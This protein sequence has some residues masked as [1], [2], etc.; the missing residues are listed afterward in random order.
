MRQEIN[1]YIGDM[2]VEFSQP[3]QILYSYTQ[4]ELTNPTII[5]NSFSK[6]IT[7]E[8]TNQNNNIFGQFW[9]LERLQDYGSYTETYFNASRKTP[10]TLYVN[11]D[12]YESGYVKLVEVRKTHNGIEYDIELFGGLGQFFYGLTYNG[13]TGNKLKLSDLDYRN[14]SDSD[15]E[16]NFT[17]DKNTLYQAWYTDSPNADSGSKWHYI[18]FAPCYNGL[19]S[20]DFAPDKVL[21]NVSGAPNEIIT[22][23]D[24]DKKII[25]DLTTTGTYITY[26]DG[27]VN[28]TLP[29]K[30][31]EWEMGDI[32]AGQ[33]RPVI[34]LKEIVN[35]CERYMAK[36]ENGSWTVEK[37][38]E[39]F[40]A[41]N[42]YWEKTWVTLPMLS[43]INY[44]NESDADISPTISVSRTS[45]QDGYSVFAVSGMTERVNKVTFAGHYGINSYSTISSYNKLYTS[46][47]VRGLMYV[48]HHTE[49]S[50]VKDYDGAVILR[51]EALNELGTVVATSPWNYLT[52]KRGDEYNWDLLN[53]FVWDY[54]T[55]SSIIQ[56]AGYFKKSGSTY[57]WVDESG[58]TQDLVFELDLQ[59]RSYSSIR[60]VVQ[61]LGNQNLKWNNTGILYG[62]SDI[63]RTYY[64]SK[65][66]VKVSDA[67][68]YNEHLDLAFISATDAGDGLLSGKVFGK[69]DILNTS[70]SPADYLIS[71]C[72]LFNLHFRKDTDK[73]IIHID[74]RKNFYQSGITIDLND[75]IDRSKKIKITPTA[76]EKQWYDFKLPLV[77]GEFAEDYKATTDFD[78]G[79]K[80]IN[81]GYDFDGDSKDLLNGNVYKSAV[82]ALEK[83]KYY[84]YCGTGVDDDTDA[85]FQPWMLEGLKYNLYNRTDSYD[86]CEIVLPI[87]YAALQGISD[88]AKYYDLYDKP[89][90]HSEDNKAIDGSNV[91]L[92]FNGFEKCLSPNSIEVNYWLTDDLPAMEALN[93][94]SCWLYTNCEKNSEGETIARKVDR[95]PKF[96]RYR[97]S[98]N[99]ISHSL[100]FGE[101][102]QLYAPNLT[103][104]E[105]ST[106]YYNYWKSY[107]EDIY[108]V[109]TKVLDCYVRLDDKPNP[110][111]LRRFYWFDNSIWRINKIEDWSISSFDTTK[112]QFIKVQDI[113]NYS[114]NTISDVGVI[115]LSA[116][117]TTVPTTGGSVTFYV[118]TTDGACWMGDENFKYYFNTTPTGCGN[119]SF[120]LTV[121][122]D[123]YGRVMNFNVIN[124]NNVAANGWQITQMPITFNVVQFAQYTYTDVPATGGTCLYQ[125]MSTTPWTVT[126]DRTYCIPQATGG[127]GNTVASETLEVVWQPNDGASERMVILTF[128]NQNGDIIIK[129]KGQEGLKYV[130]LYYE[131]SGGTQTVDADSGATISTKPDW[132]T[133]VDNE[134]GTY[135]II[136]DEND[137]DG[138]KSGIVVL[139]YDDNV[140]T[141]TVQQEVGEL[142]DSFY[143][144][145]TTLE[146]DGT[147]STA[148]LTVTNLDSD[149]WRIVAYSN[150]LSFSQ[151]SG[152][153]GATIVV[154]ASEN[155]DSEERVGVFLIYNEVTQKSYTIACKQGASEIDYFDVQPTALYYD[156]NGGTQYFN[157]INPNNNSWILSGYSWGTPNITYGV[158]SA[159]VAFEVSNNLTLQARNQYITVYNATN[160]GSSK[161]IYVEQ[162]RSSIKNFSV[163]PT[164]ITANVTG[165]TYQV[166]LTCTN[167]L[168]SDVITETHTE[169]IT[170]G[171]IN[172]A[173]SPT[174]TSVVDI[175]VP[176]NQS[177]DAH[178]YT[179]VFTLNGKSDKTATVTINQPGRTPFLTVVP[180]SLV[181]GS[182]GGTATITITTN[183]SWT[184]E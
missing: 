142:E 136:A 177:L 108:D 28:A 126:C 138:E 45:N 171:R 79:M 95:L 85:G 61:W 86:T 62:E 110:D 118:T 122:A 179:V 16:F 141:I 50:W 21:I 76:F 32:R 117:T 23:A 67:G 132:V 1:L 58:N 19:P 114:N 59:G 165:G 123:T 162:T 100:D 97:I 135:D 75:V 20:K 130:E 34:R 143:C 183:D 56:N 150:W 129:N 74:T 8:G 120:T 30:M 159:I 127:T 17:V 22:K 99:A 161:Q 168:G 65:D 24:A 153:S 163:S 144:E 63:Q 31:T 94:N 6:T 112:M 119:G 128:I 64:A 60:L 25:E 101:P 66:D 111:W 180:S 98:G 181:F 105:D 11:G 184:I 49:R 107:I 176:E 151:M 2:E 113:A 173:G 38:A 103:T 175:T 13:D 42:P 26:G 106:L 167:H 70:Y 53:G 156:D 4:D 145:P 182:T 68:S 158:T 174:G 43:E 148:N 57:Y 5:K 41:N 96:S 37:D 115:T 18:N 78:Y 169:G 164:G 29:K 140:V 92:F 15:S 160:T 52:S 172:M 77:E 152:S 48:Q 36:P 81:T 71:Y 72:K 104:L 125:V 137:T 157:I 27:Y 133:V 170:V 84:S 9:N 46:Q 88:Y 131:A 39:F 147:G 55:R 35:A 44:V 83:S 87:R 121:D 90:F 40:N 7:V 149:T 47:E 146:F 102:R 116:S 124:E 80:R 10:F 154:T 166:V 69:K 51:A 54:V 89:Q 3:P 14:Q 93:S 134:D 178:T 73:N 91:L 109:N 33:Q 155:P 139:E 12:I 82:Q